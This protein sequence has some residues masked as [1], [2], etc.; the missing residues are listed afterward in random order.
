MIV[1]D[2][3]VVTWGQTFKS[4]KNTILFH[5]AENAWGYGLRPKLKDTEELNGPK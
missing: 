4:L 5:S 3:E 2:T 1:P